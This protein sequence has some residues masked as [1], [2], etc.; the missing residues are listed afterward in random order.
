MFKL[1]DTLQTVFSCQW[2]PQHAECQHKVLLASQAIPLKTNKTNMEFAGT[3]E[4]LYGKHTG[5]NLSQS[6]K[7]GQACIHTY[8]KTLRRVSPGTRNSPNPF[9]DQYLSSDGKCFQDRT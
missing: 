7:A 2:K 5:R 4:N 9:W 1:Q 3:L 6:K 8:K